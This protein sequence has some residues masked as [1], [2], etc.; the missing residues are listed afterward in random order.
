MEQYILAHDLGTSGNKAVLYA[1]DGRLVRS[2]SWSYELLIPAANW[3]EQ[4]ADDWWTAVCETTKELLRDIPN[5]Q[6]AAISFSGQMMGCLCVDDHGVPLQNALIWADMRPVEQAKRIGS[7]IDPKNFYQLTGHRISPSYSCMKLMWLRDE[8]PDV[9]HKTYKMLNAKDY[10]LFRLTGNFVTE[11]SDAS[12]WCL[13]DMKTQTWSDELLALTELSREKLP[14][15]RRSVDLAGVV[16]KE[17]AAATG[18]LEGTPV[19]CGGGDTCCAAVGTGVIKEHTANCCM[20]TSS[21]ISVAS[22]QPVCDENMTV[23][24]WAHIVP[25]FMLPNGTM[26]T[27]GAA[28]NWMVDCLYGDLDATSGRTAEEIYCSVN[29][30]VEQ[31][32]LGANEL[33]F[34]PYLMGE[35]SP[36]WNDRARGVFEGLTLRH[37]RG[38]FLRAVMEGVGYN[39]DI[40]LR[41]LSINGCSVDRLTLVGG[42]ARNRAWRTIL[43]DIFG[44]PLVVP[45]DL[46]EATSMG[47]AITAGV[48]IGAFESFDVVNQFMQIRTQ[49]TPDFN[50]H[51][52]YDK[53]K[54]QF[55]AL[56]QAMLPLYHNF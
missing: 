41:T 46:N 49:E 10:I 21:W 53:Y 5:T 36:R 38:D 34:L 13:M 4:R 19:V 28:L 54:R 33:L 56:Y 37:R 25:G 50:R 31:T 24:N 51:L 26:Q 42:G 35:R 11:Q 27:G 1:M 14:E 8:C 29:Q 20:G 15:L 55:E 32:P 44:L 43:S 3:A 7:Q 2:T 6:I 47:A 52:A 23:I 48:G 22:R 39:L 12:S 45:A 17:A 9:Y 18:L 40:I 30:A 16:T